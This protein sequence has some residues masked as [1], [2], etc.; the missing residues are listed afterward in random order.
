MEMIDF[1]AC[2]DQT[3]AR[4]REQEYFISL[5]A[6]LNSVEPMPKPK[7]AEPLKKKKL[8]I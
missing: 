6:N 2:K 3:E 5:N 7:V 8:V 1:F 4:E